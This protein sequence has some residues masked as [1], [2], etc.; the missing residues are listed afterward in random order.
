MGVKVAEMA[1]QLVQINY[2]RIRH[3]LF[4]E[5][6]STAAHCSE[7]MFIVGDMMNINAIYFPVFFIHIVIIGASTIPWT[8]GS[9]RAAAANR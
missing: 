7:S 2:V 1:K 8:S 9:C 4:L 6:P 3:G 5:R